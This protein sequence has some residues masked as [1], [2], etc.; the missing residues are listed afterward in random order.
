MKNVIVTIAEIFLGV[1]LFMLIF[2]GETSLRSEADVIF[3]KV[4]DQMAKLNYTK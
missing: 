2:G 1:A 3:E 4:V